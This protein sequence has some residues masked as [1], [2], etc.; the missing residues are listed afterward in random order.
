MDT[1]KGKEKKN[2]LIIVFEFIYIELFFSDEH[3]LF[4]KKEFMFVQ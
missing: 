1:D 3:D 2:S 4:E